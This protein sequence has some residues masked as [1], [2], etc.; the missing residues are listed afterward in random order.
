M[1]NTQC[2]LTGVHVSADACG[3]ESFTAHTSFSCYFVGI[4]TDDFLFQNKQELSFGYVD[5]DETTMK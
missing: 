4:G 2:P 3:G 1:F 5:S